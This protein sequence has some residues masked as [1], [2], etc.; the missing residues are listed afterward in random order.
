MP[1]DQGE[2]SDEQNEAGEVEDNAQ[3][4]GEQDV[5]GVDANMR[6]IDEGGCEAPA[7][8]IASA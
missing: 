7:D 4:G 6:A 2:E 1:R 3:P 5:E 8:P